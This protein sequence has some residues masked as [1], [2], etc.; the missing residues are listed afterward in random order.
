MT[1]KP[2]DDALARA[3]DAVER[4]FA[5]RGWQPAP[6][7]EKAWDAY[8]GG[9]SGLIHSE[10]GSG[11]SLAAWL[12][13]V[14]E[15][16]AHP[17]TKPTGPRVL[18]ITPLKALASDT[19]AS[20]REPLDGLGLNW[21]VEQRTGD[22]GSSARERQRRH[23]PEALVTTP[24]SLALMIAYRGAEQRLSGVEAVI[25]DE[26]HELLGSKRG[27]QLELAL[28]FLR[29]L[30]P[31][32][33]TWG[34]SATLGNLD[35]A[36]QVLLG[37]GD[38]DGVR[39]QGSNDKP[40]AIRGLVP[41]TGTRFPWAG[42]LGLNLLSRVIETI[43][44]ARSCLLFTNTR[45]QAERWH[46][47]IVA[48]RP[49]WADTVALHHGSIERDQREAI[50][51]GLRDGQLRCVVATSSLD[52]G[53]DFSPVDRVIQ[54]G[55]PKGVARL[56]QR[57]GRSGH[58]PGVTSEVLCVPSHAFELVEIAAARRAKGQEAIEARHPLT[59]SLDVLTQHLV[60]LATGDGFRE[61]ETLT[62]VRRTH[63]YQD[64]TDTEWQW[65]MAFITQGGPVLANYPQF[66]RVVWDGERY[67]VSDRGIAMRHRMS[68]GTITS[69]PAI[70]VQYVRGGRLGSV[71]E[72]FIASLSPGDRFLF[73]GRYLE[74]VRVRD[75]TAYVRQA[76]GPKRQVPRWLGGHL[77]MSTTLAA[78]VRECLADVRNDRADEPEVTALTATFE[79]QQQWSSLPGPGELLVERTRTREGE[80]LFV[81]P[82]AGRLAHEGLA[83]LLAW[84]LAQQRP[85]T[86]SV[87]VNDYGLELL[88][89]KRLGITADELAAVL[90][91]SN[92]ADDLEQCL[93]AG[94]L[95]R[96]R[97]RAIAR[98]AGLVF[99]GYPGKAKGARQ[100]QAS[101]GLIFDTLQRYAPEHRLLDQAREEV[102]SQQLEYQRLADCLA[103]L[104]TSRIVFH[105][106]PRLTPLA[107]PLWAERL[108]NRLS[109]ED[110]Q[111][112]IERMIASLER[113]AG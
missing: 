74:L 34:L 42:H 86:F 105:D 91:R 102:L 51:A 64:L 28:A 45:S 76:G 12:G 81:F 47:A 32:L 55:S 37:P 104:E 101:S 49:D 62:E 39:I 57:A 97:F 87:A 50:E 11:K 58:Q 25:V 24:E 53:V 89:G 106:T 63:A 70:R 17:A 59:R 8:L 73:A 7:Q 6:F 43:E 26:W 38:T 29:G 96:R 84:R 98:I 5:D 72:S 10:T 2:A 92:L 19:V 52:L 14:M 88:S 103:E 40:I 79:V 80:H 35:E 31:G 41:E 56:L 77:P 27:V 100:L 1:T 66:R 33:R 82:F 15:G 48:E 110:W 109:S 113:A 23:P 4:W 85:A 83:S 68:V 18:W 111:A 61:A 99:T 90:T 44:A 65:V 107:F 16:L 94:E 71:E 112:R 69:D 22:T 108:R 20:L 21:R 30:N 93:N 60:T 46:E 95:A 67:R 78:A 9:H 75:T 3:R 13:P 36:Q 54:V